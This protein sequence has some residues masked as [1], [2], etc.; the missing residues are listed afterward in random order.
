MEAL[1]READAGRF[2]AGESEEGAAYGARDV[3]ALRGA[4]CR[5]GR[6]RIALVLDAQMG[7]AEGVQGWCRVTTAL[8]TITMLSITSSQ[9]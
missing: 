3:G 5:W 8:P 1:L 9:Y 6:S 4:H 7:R 2:A